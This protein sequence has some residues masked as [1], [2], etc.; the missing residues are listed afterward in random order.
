MTI[1]NFSGIC[2]IDVIKCS[3]FIFCHVIS[4]IWQ[5]SVKIS[6]PQCQFDEAQVLKVPLHL[7]LKIT[8]SVI[9]TQACVPEEQSDKG[10]LPTSRIIRISNKLPK[11]GSVESVYLILAK[12][13]CPR[14]QVPGSSLGIQRRTDKSLAPKN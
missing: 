4:K 8:N 2:I 12:L 14:T 3:P 13:Q 9:R 6:V 10:P 1:W 5:H 11:F 7:Y